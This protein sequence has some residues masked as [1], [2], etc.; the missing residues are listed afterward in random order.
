LGTSQVAA[1]SRREPR[2]NSTS[3]KEKQIA[4]V[5]HLPT[6]EAIITTKSS[7]PKSRRQPSNSGTV[8]KA[9][10]AAEQPVPQS[11][12]LESDQE[13]ESQDRIYKD[14]VRDEALTLQSSDV[15]STRPR[16]VRKAKGKAAVAAIVVDDDSDD[17]ATFKGFQRKRGKRV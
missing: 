2:S 10:R 12:F 3:Q 16:T 1:S 15:A 8:K 9:S 5:D 13:D 14:Q 7:Q 17:G 4:A 11:L 6:I